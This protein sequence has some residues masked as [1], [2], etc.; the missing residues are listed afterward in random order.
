MYMYILELIHHL[1]VTWHSDRHCSYSTCTCIVNRVSYIH[2]CN[3][4][5][6]G[7]RMYEVYFTEY[8]PGCCLRAGDYNPVI[9]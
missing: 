7:Y 8:N 4:Q 2:V 3:K 6:T 9:D 1:A 5:R